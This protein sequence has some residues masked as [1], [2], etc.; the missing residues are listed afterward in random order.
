[1]LEENVR[2]KEV[3]EIVGTVRGVSDPERHTS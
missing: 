1:M 2:R 3:V